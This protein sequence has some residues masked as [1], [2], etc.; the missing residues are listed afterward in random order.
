MKQHEREYFTSRIRSGIINI[1]LDTVNLKIQPITLEEEL[2]VQET[3]MLAY[4]KAKQDGFLENDEILQNLRDRGVWTTQDDEK[5]KGLEKDIERLKVELFQNKNKSDWVQQIKK[6]LS[7]G[8]KQLN[9]LLERKHQ[10]FENSCEGLSQ[11]EKIKK[12]IELSCYKED[13]TAYVKYDFADI[14][15]D[16][17]IKLY[18]YQLLSETT[19]RELARSEPWRSTWILKDSNAYELFANKGKQLT[20]DQ[21]S[22][23]IWSKMYDN[24]QESI[25]AP[26][27]DV[28]EDDDMLDG[29]FILQRKKRDQEKAKSD[30]EK[31]TSNSKI[32]NSSEIFVMAHNKKDADKI[33][34]SN[35]FA[36]QKVK[37][38]RSQLI[39]NKGIAEDSDFQDQQL[40]ATQQSNEMYKGRFRR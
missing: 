34:N 21:R 39:Q 27:D 26:S 7:A 13:N 37:Q 30:I 19:V 1:K 32:S 20:Q 35:N 12:L 6:Y 28:I 11:V 18:G 10:Y 25:D 29:W 17:I 16:Y 24:V 8:K 33:N 14:P 2:Q 9:E 31:M 36:A 15:I 23:L 22:L 38:Q 4:R 40:R 3:Y 5:E